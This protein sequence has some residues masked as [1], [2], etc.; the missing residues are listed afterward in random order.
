MRVLGDRYE[1]VR[2]VGRGGM[3][4][5]WEGRDR[6]IERRVAIKL[7]PPHHG[8]AA[9]A[10]LFFREA[11]TAGG[12]NHRGVVTVHDVGRDRGDGTLFLVMEFV[13]GRDLAAV[14]RQDGPPPVPVAADW[15]AQAAAAL[16]AA[17]DAGIVHRDLKPANLML[18]AEGDVK[19]LD[20]GIA[21]FMAATDKS[22]K[23]MG[24][25]AY[26]APERFRE[27]GG[28]ARTDLYALGC[29]LHEL[30]TGV[31][32]FQAS[33]PVAMMAAHVQQAPDAPGTLRPGIPAAV[34]DLVI[35]LLAKAPSD[36]PASAAEVHDALR[37]P[38]A[39]AGALPTPA[40][41]AATPDPT[42]VDPTPPLAPVTAPVTAPNPSPDPHRLPTR[43]ATPPRP[44]H[45]PTDGPE[46]TQPRSLGRRRALR[47]AFGAALVAGAGTGLA[48]LP[49]GDQQE[50]STAA[51]GQ[52]GAPSLAL[53]DARPWRFDAPM[54]IPKGPVLS[55]GVLYLM[56]GA[57]IH[58]VDARTGK[59]RATLTVPDPQVGSGWLAAAAGTLFA[60]GAKGKLYALNGADGSTRWTFAAGDDIGCDPT[61]AGGLVYVGSLDKNLH[62]V[63]AATGAQKWAF[64]TGDFVLS[65]ATVSGGTVYVGGDDKHFYAVDAATGAKKWAFGAGG[66]FRATAAV[67]HGTVYVP[68]NDQRLYALDAATGAQRWTAPLGG[69][70]TPDDN[71]R[72]SCP[73]VTAD[74]LYVGGRDGLLHAL[75][76]TTGRRKWTYGTA[77][78]FRPTTPA[79]AD[80]TVYVGNRAEAQGTLHAVDAATGTKRWSVRTGG[81]LGDTYAPVVAD[82]LVYLTNRAGLSAVPTA[83]GPGRK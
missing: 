20:F 32:P 21:R 24:T 15:A 52:G 73:V 5:V 49:W 79:V 69:G 76:P 63:D 57:T 7:L 3:G 64:P 58:A 66:T 39:T 37:T 67:A 46:P 22:S 77:G 65:T 51:G 11:R 31:P 61:V 80:G 23:V 81:A 9:G 53:A 10:E 30:L 72:P 27:H 17:H 43:T 48:L 45:P 82:G 35:R 14:L 75:D 68:N 2:F 13:V 36:R 34:D 55:R 40:A 60:V 12:L 42:A 25:L 54:I 83:P 18:T 16:A 6:V 19:V 71:D 47:L 26:M 28:D 59:Q 1:L 78:D 70:A 33:D 56:D 50:P 8:D 4:E 74:I 29:V 44:P 41:T 62:A 38:T